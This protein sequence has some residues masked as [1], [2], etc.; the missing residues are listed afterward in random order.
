MERNRGFPS[1]VWINSSVTW[2]SQIATE[3]SSSS[4]YFEWWQPWLTLTAISWD[5]Q[6][7]PVQTCCSRIPDPYTVRE[8]KVAFFM[9]LNFGVTCNPVFSWW[10]YRPTCR[11][12]T[13]WL[14][15]NT[16]ICWAASLRPTLSQLQ[17]WR[18]SPQQATETSRVQWLGG[19][20]LHTWSKVPEWHP[21]MGGRQWAGYISSLCSQEEG[22]VAS[23][24]GNQHLGSL[25]TRKTTRGMPLTTPLIRAVTSWD[26]G[27]GCGK[28]H[29]VSWV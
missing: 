20:I 4:W 26:L 2:M 19:Q 12:G 5:T 11:V 8:N 3:S 27:Q 9:L 28:V 18:K 6:A 13:Q 21:D 1:R 22:E 25:V 23:Y 14:V 15:T 24:R 7:R 29:Q 16:G 17:D 10:T